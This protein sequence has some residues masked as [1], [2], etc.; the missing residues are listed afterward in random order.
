MDDRDLVLAARAAIE[1]KNREYADDPYAWA[2]ERVKTQDEATQRL[3]MFPDWDYIKDLYECLNE[4]QMVVIPKSRRMFV[5]WA[6]S[7]YFL[8]R[9]RYHP[10][11]AVYWQSL[12]EE[13]AAYIVD[14]RCA[15]VENNLEGLWR[16]KYKPIK[17]KSGL[18]GKIVY[19]ETGSYMLAIPQGDD[20][21][22]SLT[23]SAL[24]CDEMDFQPEAQAALKAALSTVEKNMTMVLVTTSNG[25]NHPVA[26]ICKGVGFTRF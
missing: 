17:T 3:E 7:I 15:L 24:V 14:Q 6:V 4:E 11:N 5:S 12:T 20:Q 9:I 26:D 18:I 22:R 23:P 25:P 13:R 8:H 2:R 21:I 1:I 10:H 16:K 19:E